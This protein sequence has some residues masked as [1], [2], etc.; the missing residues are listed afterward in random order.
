MV[1]N[2]SLRVGILNADPVLCQHLEA[3]ELPESTEYNI[4]QLTVDTT[5][6]LPY[7]FCSA[8]SDLMYGDMCAVEFLLL[9][10]FNY[11]SCWDSGKTWKTGLR[12]LS[13]LMGISVRYIRQ[14]LS[15]L[16]EK[17]WLHV[18]SVGINTGS[19]Y[20]VVHHNCDRDEVPTDKNGNPLKFA[21]PRGAGGILERMF[22]GDICWKSAVLWI[23]L[24]FRSDWKTGITNALSIDKL[25]KLLGMSP[26]TVVNCIK[27]L[28]KA[29][30]LKRLSKKHEAGV[31]QLYPKPDGKPKP[32]YRKRKPKKEHASNDKRMRDDGDWRYSYNELWR[33]NVETNQIQRR[34]SKRFGIW[35]NT[36]EHERYTQMPKSMRDDFE[37]AYDFYQRMK[38]ELG[39]TDSAR[40]VTDNTQGVTHTAQDVLSRGFDGS[41]NKGS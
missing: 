32:V 34:K 30:L 31:Y 8:L 27:E 33:I 11:R 36:S 2:P 17:G 26:Q 23:V 24:K 39:V 10:V 14:K 35:R 22:S 3:P 19:I 20:E 9:S 15:N 28:T 12:N 40:S 13:E 6:Q 29:G 1:L 37:K 41:G 5:M 4:P 38:L 18:L 16:K 21:V 25:R 7:G